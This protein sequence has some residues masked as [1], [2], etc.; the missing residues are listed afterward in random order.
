M[1][2]T[3]Q[4]RD[5]DDI[6][7]RSVQEDRANEEELYEL[8]PPMTESEDEGG[9]EIPILAASEYDEESVLGGATPSLSGLPPASM[10]S[11]IF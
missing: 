3:D 1:Q 6:E 4:E 5:D 7:E 2:L 8:P 10:Y 9:S 11:R